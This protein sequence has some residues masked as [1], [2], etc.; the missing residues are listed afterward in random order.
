MSFPAFNFGCTLSN[1]LKEGDGKVALVYGTKYGSTMETSIWMAEGM[2]RMVDVIDIE[3]A[4]VK[5]LTREYDSYVFGSGIWKAG[6]HKE[7]KSFLQSRSSLLDGRVL[8]SFVVCGSRGEDESSRKRISRYLDQINSRLRS[9]PPLSQHFGGRLT[10]EKLT[11]EDR[12]ALE[13]FYRVYLRKELESW[14]YMDKEKALS[15]GEE[16]DTVSSSQTV[17]PPEETVRAEAPSDGSGSCLKRSSEAE[18]SSLAA[19]GGRCF[20]L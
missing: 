17:V 14:N 19:E 16:M 2:N 6:I 18:P 12:K 3:K 4:D 5:R 20:A 9:Q 13:K 15:F 7:L 8:A 1:F 10:V 11:P